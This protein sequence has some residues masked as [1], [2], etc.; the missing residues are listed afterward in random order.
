MSVKKKVLPGS[1]LM[2][3]KGLA[4]VFYV[5]KEDAGVAIQKLYFENELG[6]NLA[7]D[8]YK[9]KEARISEHDK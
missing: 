5:R 2:V 9:L 3:S 4:E 8:F 1:E 6:D 7:L